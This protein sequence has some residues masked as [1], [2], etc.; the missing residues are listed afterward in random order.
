MLRQERHAC[1]HASGRQTESVTCGQ[2]ACMQCIAT[3]LQWR[4][5]TQSAAPL[6]S[7]PD[8]IE[9]VLGEAAGVELADDNRELVDAEALGQ[10]R[11][12]PRLPAGPHRAQRRLPEA[13][14]EA[15]C[16]IRPLER[17]RRVGQP[18]ISNL[19]SPGLN[20]RFKI[21]TAKARQFAIAAANFLISRSE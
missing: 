12:L 13:R 5:R 14:L 8:L 11:V 20:F 6:T 1:S 18:P 16:R 9:A 7:A 15:A 4:S 19:M 2:S 21:Q 3:H 10:L 17:Q